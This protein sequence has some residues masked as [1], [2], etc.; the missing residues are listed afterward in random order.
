LVNAI[1]EQARPF[2]ADH[3]ELGVLQGA[4]AW[5]QAN[6]AQGEEA[7]KLFGTAIGAGP[8]A[9]YFYGRARE[10]MSM[11]N[12]AAALEDVK[13][14]LA[15]L[16]DDPDMLELQMRAFANLRQ[17]KQ[18]AAAFA[19][20]EE[21]DATNERLPEWREY[22][23]EVADS[24]A[25]SAARGEL[26]EYLKKDAALAAR[27]DWNGI[28]EMW[29]SYLSQHPNDGRAYLERAGAERRKGDMAAARSDI[30]S[31]CDLG[32]AQACEIARSMGWQ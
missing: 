30:K 23:Q 7:V 32:S 15:L 8:Y 21:I 12:A 9:P 17:D 31:A 14:A 19:V 6:L 28:I 4:V 3:P 11:N 5:D 2:L 16:P 13:L 29:S 27:G 22:F 26:N 1:W 25:A 24:A 10:H 18:A 20:L